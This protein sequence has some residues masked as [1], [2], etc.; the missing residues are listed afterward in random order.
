MKKIMKKIYLFLVLLF[1][2]N[3][4]IAQTFC[5]T[6]SNT[7]NFLNSTSRLIVPAKSYQIRIFAHIIRTSA[8]SGG[9]TQTELNSAIDILSQDYNPLNISFTLVGQDYINS[10]RYFN[11]SINSDIF[12]VNTT[13][14]AI[15]IYFLPNSCPSPGGLAENIVSK[16]FVVGGTWTF[17]SPSVIVNTSRIVS[18]EMGHCLG[19]YHTHHGTSNEGTLEQCPE[20]VNGTNSSTCGDYVTDTPAD[21]HLEF[22]VNTSCNWLGA[23]RDINGQSYRPDTRIIMSYT[24][25]SCMQYLTDGQAERIFL[26]LSNNKVLQDV[27][28]PGG[29]CSND[30]IANTNV[31]TGEDNKQASNSIVAT[32]VINNGAS[33]IYHAPLVTLKPSFNAKTGSRVR[34]YP[35]GC[36][37]TFLA[38]QSEGTTA[39]TDDQNSKEVL[40]KQIETINVHPNPSNGIFNISLNEVSKG[41]VQVM[42]LFGFVVYETDFENKTDFEINIQERQKGIYIVKVFSGEKVYTN[43][44][45]KN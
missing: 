10:D 28:V 27:S 20:L 6:P 45:I 31:T 12:K 3:N 32:N 41:T 1:A 15:D 35:E 29:D 19:L 34:I 7:P 21:P 36:T 8:G 37:N 5:K 39:T 13:P 40:I 42:D 11:G 17:N 22:N 4:N 16:A 38:R 30:L 24:R 25:P 9:M 2:M 33:A 14:N 23:G 43:K 26:S 18:H 44:I